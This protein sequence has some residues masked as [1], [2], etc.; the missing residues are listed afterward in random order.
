MYLISFAI[1][2]IKKMFN[3]K[4]KKTTSISEHVFIHIHNQYNKALKKIQYNI[5]HSYYNI[6]KIYSYII[7]SSYKRILLQIYQFYLFKLF[8]ITWLGNI[9]INIIRLSNR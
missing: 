4:K 3:Q 9:I 7:L 1:F 5:F 2:Y 8:L 6:N